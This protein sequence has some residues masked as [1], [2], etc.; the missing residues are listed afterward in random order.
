MN[1]KREKILKEFYAIFDMINYHC[2]DN[3]IAQAEFEIVP[4]IRGAQACVD[5]SYKIQISAKE[6]G[7]SN[8]NIIGVIAHEM[9]HIWQ[10]QHCMDANHN[11]SFY[12]RLEALGLHFLCVS[13]Q[14]ENMFFPVND[15]NLLCTV[16]P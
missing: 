15:L 4:Y 16:L 7:I 8:E 3:K 14:Q 10:W 12:R 6:I 1:K 5:P 11:R 2:F 9:V 13:S